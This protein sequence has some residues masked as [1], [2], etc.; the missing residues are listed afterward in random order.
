MRVFESSSFCLQPRGDTLTRR[1]TFDAILAGCIPVFFH[2]GSAYT[3]YTAH[4]PK[5]PNSYSVL[6]MHTD[7]TGR[8]VSIEDTLSNISPAARR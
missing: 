8:N 5:D 1:S 2:P 4:L 7:V 6:I 3:Q